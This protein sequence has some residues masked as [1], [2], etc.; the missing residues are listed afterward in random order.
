MKSIHLEQCM[1]CFCHL[2][3]AVFSS[4]DPVRDV[5]LGQAPVLF[6]GEPGGLLV[7]HAL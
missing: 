1:S 6:S 5:G 7:K 2:W 4:K 3:P